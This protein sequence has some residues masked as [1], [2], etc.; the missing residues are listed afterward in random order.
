VVLIAILVLAFVT[1]PS[2]ELHRAAIREKVS[3]IAPI[4]SVFGAG[5]IAAWTTQYHSLGVA[6][7]TVR[8]GRVVSIGA[9]GMVHVLD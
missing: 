9:F 7:Y 2:L 1:N 3:N 6:S 5:Q 4:A 8:D